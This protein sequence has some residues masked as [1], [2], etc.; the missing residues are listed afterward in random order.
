[1]KHY[2][3]IV[4]ISIVLVS[5]TNN[6]TT[7]IER[8]G[9]PEIYGFAENDEEMN[10]AIKMA[11]ETL[12]KFNE[13]LKSSNPAFEYFALKTKFNTSN[14]SEHIWVSSITLKDNKYFG[15]VDNLP[16]FTTDVNLGDT[17]EIKEEDIS[18]WMYIENQKLQGGYTIKVLRNSMTEEERKQFDEEYGLLIED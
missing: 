2:L 9:E 14:G 16:E 15:V 8:E 6:K 17:I 12:D 4:I 5:C 13:A 10:Q 11:K 1:M 18:D 3:L 7:K